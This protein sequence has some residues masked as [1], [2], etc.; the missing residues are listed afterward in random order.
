MAIP[1]L[2]LNSCFAVAYLLTCGK[3]LGERQIALPGASEFYALDT[4]GKVPCKLKGLRPAMPRP[5]RF[6][7]FLIHFKA[8][9]HGGGGSL[10]SAALKG[11][12]LLN[13]RCAVNP[14]K[15]DMKRRFG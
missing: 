12:I 8:S 7:D 10:S 9:R 4:G 13:G 14:A 2:R 11:A 15:A 1:R 6:L 5:R 3:R